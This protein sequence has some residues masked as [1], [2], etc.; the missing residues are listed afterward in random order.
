[1]H[2]PKLV[3]RREIHF[4]EAK[5]PVAKNRF[6]SRFPS[7]PAL[8]VFGVP[9][10]DSHARVL[11]PAVD[12][13]QNIGEHVAA[14]VELLRTK[15]RDDVQLPQVREVGVPDAPSQRSSNELWRDPT[16]QRM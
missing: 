12:S 1:M 15:H 14:D 9:N 16:A 10:V 3:T 7:C 13:E 2:V 11:Q 8:S 4:D 5:W 6:S